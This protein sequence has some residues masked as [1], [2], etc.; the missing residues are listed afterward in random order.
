MVPVWE[1]C[2]VLEQQ[3]QVHWELKEGNWES[4][5]QVRC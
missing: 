2:Q 5:E 4:A 3:L 1:F